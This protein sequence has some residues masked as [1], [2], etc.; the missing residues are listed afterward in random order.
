MEGISPRLPS[1]SSQAPGSSISESSSGVRA[2]DSVKKR[3]KAGSPDEQSIHRKKGHH[4]V[5]PH[6]VKISAHEEQAQKMDWPQVFNTPQYFPEEIVCR[7]KVNKLIR[8]HIFDMANKFEEGLYNKVVELYEDV[9]HNLNGVEHS[10]AILKYIR[11]VYLISRINLISE[12]L[13]ELT[14]GLSFPSIPEI[15]ST[16][17]YVVFL[18]NLA[19]AAKSGSVSID[20]SS[21]LNRLCNRKAVVVGS[22][23]ARKNIIIDMLSEEVD[24]KGKVVVHPQCDSEFLENIY[25]YAPGDCIASEYDEVISQLQHCMKERSHDQQVAL[26]DYLSKDPRPE[27]KRLAPMVLLE[28]LFGSVDTRGARK[29]VKALRKD[30]DTSMIVEYWQQLTNLL[31]GRKEAVDRLLDMGNQ[32]VVAAYSLLLR[33]YRVN[34]DFLTSDQLINIYDCNFTYRDLS[35]ELASMMLRLSYY[36]DKIEEFRNH[37]GV[38]DT[39]SRVGVFVHLCADTPAFFDGLYESVRHY[40]SDLSSIPPK[41]VKL[42]PIPEEFKDAIEENPFLDDSP[43]GIFI[44]AYQV[45]SRSDINDQLLERCMNRNLPETLYW[46]I[47]LNHFPENMAMADMVH[48]FLKESCDGLDCLIPLIH[49]FSLP[50]FL[51][52]VYQYGVFS[53]LSDNHPVFD[54]A[55]FFRLI[56]HFED[57]VRCLASLAKFKELNNQADQAAE[58]LWMLRKN[59]GAE[60][61]DSKHGFYVFRRNDDGWKIRSCALLY[62]SSHP[63]GDVYRFNE[64]VQI[65]DL[66]DCCDDLNLC[67]NL[68]LGI[69]ECLD[70]ATQF[71]SKEIMQAVFSKLGGFLKVFRAGCPDRLIKTCESITSWLDQ[72]DSPIFQAKELRDSAEKIKGCSEQLSRQVIQDFSEFK[73]KLAKQSCSDGERYD[74]ELSLNQ[75]SNTKLHQDRVEHESVSGS[76]SCCGSSADSC[77]DDEHSPDN[78]SKELFPIDP[79]LMINLR[80]ETD[81]ACCFDLL[82]KL[83]SLD[84]SDS[85]EMIEQAVQKLDPKRSECVELVTRILKDADEEL[86]KSISLSSFLNSRYV[87]LLQQ[88]IDQFAA[89]ALPCSEFEEILYQKL[90][91]MALY[92]LAAL[93]YLHSHFSNPLPD[94]YGLLE[95]MAGALEGDINEQLEKLATGKGADARAFMT[96]AKS[97]NHDKKTS[98]I[99][100]SGPSPNTDVNGSPPGIGFSTLFMKLWVQHDYEGLYRLI[101]VIVRGNRENELK[102]SNALWVAYESGILSENKHASMMALMDEEKRSPEYYFHSLLTESNPDAPIFIGLQLE[103]RLMALTEP[104]LETVARKLVEIGRISDA[105]WLTRTYGL[106]DFEGVLNSSLGQGVSASESTFDDLIGPPVEKLIA[107]AKSG[108]GLAQMKLMEYVLEKSQQWDCESVKHLQNICSFCIHTPGLLTDG[109]RLIYQGIALCTGIAGHEVSE[110]GKVKLRAAL[111]SHDPVVPLILHK[112]ISRFPWFDLSYRKEDLLRIFLDYLP[113]VEVGSAKL[114]TEI[115]LAVGH[116]HFRRVAKEVAEEPSLRA[117]PDSTNSLKAKSLSCWFDKWSEQSSYQNMSPAQKLIYHFDDQAKNGWPI[118]NLHALRDKVDR[119]DPIHLYHS[120]DFQRELIFYVKRL[121]RLSDTHKAFA[122][123]LCNYISSENRHRLLLNDHRGKK[124][125]WDSPVFERDNKWMLFWSMPVGYRHQLLL[126]LVKEINSRSELPVHDGAKRNMDLKRMPAILLQEFVKETKSKGL[127]YTE[128]ALANRIHSVAKPG[129]KKYK[130]F[131]LLK[132]LLF[133]DSSG[134]NPDDRKAF[135]ET[136][137]NLVMDAL[138]GQIDAKNETEVLSMAAIFTLT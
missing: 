96:L 50:V 41:S 132:Y 94:Y 83:I 12:D 117:N 5:S 61:Q 63:V 13:E 44:H 16:D 24:E 134:L 38:Q 119:S 110:A 138:K 102:A 127:E 51:E 47:V 74:L 98:R 27:V 109:C 107:G 23:Q 14:P 22:H 101:E 72:S 89:K 104:Q 59:R 19:E 124:L 103:R 34:P 90:S 121:I 53:K 135:R 70:G 81:P 84:E 131:E 58:Y 64:L 92:D 137:R 120:T 97:V 108:H 36:C 126:S 20:K 6:P 80:V 39:I 95:L 37:V 26:C 123:F 11:I 32:G 105:Q 25:R 40:F 8:T 76:D 54:W 129:A 33:Q 18:L 2:V 78:K 21:N 71:L 118:Q 77:S 3:L 66:F 4:S 65:F 29:I 67:C 49:T 73:E 17:E 56:P 30:G 45:L 100:E 31:D 87:V 79:I 106:S 75:S 125:Y 128:A 122:G 133:I 86:K 115:L 112:M 116:E 93:K 52:K 42:L 113:E 7:L 55:N 114:M 9:I 62:Q 43:L 130:Y 85:H 60:F 48:T 82:K 91:E 68:I 57:G 1:A 28:S 35:P 69:L 136:I 46:M 99:Q 10:E 15:T 111:D 88:V